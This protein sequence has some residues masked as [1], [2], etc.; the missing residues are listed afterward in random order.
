MWSSP[1]P[2]ARWE[3][4][5]FQTCH[6]GSRRTHGV[7]QASIIDADSPASHG[8]HQDQLV[9]LI[10]NHSHPAFLR[11]HLGGTDPLAIIY[12]KHVPCIH[13]LHNLCLD[14]CLQVRSQSPLRLPDWLNLIRIL[15]EQKDGL[16]PL[17]SVILHA[18]ARAYFFNK[19]TSLLF[20]SDVRSELIMTE[21]LFPSRRNSY[22]K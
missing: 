12:S 13:Q 22:S 11:D 2:L 14:H 10:R 1:D 19:A 16:M 3:S 21:S 5:S 7:V 8:L 9:L 15:W 20:C 17:M 18:M 4:G 6:L